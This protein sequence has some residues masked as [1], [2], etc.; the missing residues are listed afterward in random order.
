MLF[1]VNQVLDGKKKLL[2]LPEFLGSGKSAKILSIADLENGFK[3]TEYFIKK[4]LNPVKGFQTDH[5]FRLRNR[6]LSLNML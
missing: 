4:I 2:V 3:L 5:F 1:Q 6:V